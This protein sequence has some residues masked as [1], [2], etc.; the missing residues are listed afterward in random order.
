MRD[1][2][3]DGSLRL[4][5]CPG[6][7]HHLLVVPRVRLLMTGPARTGCYAVDRVTGKD[8]SV[9]PRPAR[10]GVFGSAEVARE[11]V[12]ARRAFPVACYRVAELWQGRGADGRLLPAYVP[13]DPA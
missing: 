1:V 4:E 8:G 7:D 12:S 3:G 5:E 6:R 9:L 2:Q 13:G 11:F 10:M